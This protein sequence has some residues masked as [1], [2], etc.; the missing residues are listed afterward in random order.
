VDR[1]ETRT[2]LKNA[3][4][5]VVR[6]S[7]AALVAIVSPIFLTRLMVPAAFSAWALVLQLSAYTGYL[8]FGIQTAVG[9]F[10][11]HANERGDAEHRDR[12]ASTSFAVLSL[13]GLFGVCGIAGLALTMPHIFRQMPET[14]VGGSRVAL[15]LVGSSLAIG[16]P[17]SVFNGIFIGYQRN[18][19]PAAIIGGS[20]VFGAALLIV[21]VVHGGSLTAMG[22]TIAAVNFASYGVQYVMYRKLVPAVRLS[23]HCVSREAGHELLDYCLSLSVWSFAMLL[24]NGMDVVLVGFFQFVAVA[25]Y[26]VAASL[27]TFFAGLQNA[28]FS[29]MIPSTAVLHARGEAAELG[30]TMINAT[31]Y[32]TFLLLI[33]ALTLIFGAKSILTVWVG[34]A[35]GVP[36][37]QFLRILLIANVVRLSTTPYIITLIGTGQQRLV[38]LMPLLEGFTN[39]ALSI[40]WGMRYGAIGVAAGTLF[41]GIVGFAGTIFYNMRRTTSFEFRIADYVRDGLLR[42]TMCLAPPIVF[43]IILRYWPL[44]PMAI[45]LGSIG[46]FIATT[47]LVWHWGLLS[48]ERERLKSWRLA[49]QA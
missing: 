2:L 45:G 35:Y 36:A 22:T 15:I 3:L 17:A 14:F 42:P 6:G 7:A 32:G 23:T 25:P 34:P 27:I 5:N 31:R 28:L 13:A 49:P 8:D 47:V 37:V 29:A 1:K 30:R 21:V 39:I 24:V 38:I 41:G 12:I 11:A 33:A 9:R 4:A 19:V 16:L 10:V 18:E 43:A 40:I 26:T 48:S 44:N 46:T 20:K